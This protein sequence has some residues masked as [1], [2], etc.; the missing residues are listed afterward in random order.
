MRIETT[1]I[2]GAA[3][4]APQRIEDERGFFARTWCERELADRLGGAHLV[5]TSI[6]F[7]PR[8]GTLRG[9]HFQAPPGR[10]HKLVRCTRGRAFDAIVDLRPRSPS[11]LVSVSVVLDADERNALWV[12]AGCAH[13]YLTLS[14][15]TEVLY[16]MTE[17]H[18]PE[19]ARGVRWNDP[20]FGIDWPA[21]PLVIGA[22]DAAYPDY[23]RAR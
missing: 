6:A 1:A 12:P 11:Y 10:E 8:A 19:L 4:I 14:D 5:Q 22:R 15:D 18:A 3:L 20:A 9:L 23:V 13:G 16:G 17:F 21:A 7:N 2:D